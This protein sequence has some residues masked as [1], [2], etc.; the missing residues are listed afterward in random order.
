[1]AV[2]EVSKTMKDL[3]KSIENLNSLLNI[4]EKSISESSE[5]SRKL[6]NVVEKLKEVSTKLISEVD[7]FKINSTNH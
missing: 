7:N 1:M 4:V 6:S 5:S 3:V 2:E